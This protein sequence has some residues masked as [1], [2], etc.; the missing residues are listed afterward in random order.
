MREKTGQPVGAGP[1]QG[2]RAPSIIARGRLMRRLSRVRYRRAGTSLFVTSGVTLPPWPPLMFQLAST[3]EPHRCPPATPTAAGFH[4]PSISQEQNTDA[5][6]GP[7]H[8]GFH[9]VIDSPS[10]PQGDSVGD[11]PIH[12]L[13]H[14]GIRLGTDH[15]NDPGSHRENDF[16]GHPPIHPAVQSVV[17]SAIHPGSHHPD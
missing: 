11:W 15:R 2:P 6:A 4:R 8:S 9:L 14:S 7:R 1:P 17:Q 16:L 12:S 5:G 10:H 13:G 3:W